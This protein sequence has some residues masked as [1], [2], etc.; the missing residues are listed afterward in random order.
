[1]A[2]TA[3]TGNPVL[4]FI[5]DTAKTDKV[6]AGEMMVQ[7]L[8]AGNPDTLTLG[9]SFGSALIATA[10]HLDLT[11]RETALVAASIHDELVAKAGA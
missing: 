4:D 6:A 10:Q 11:P 1:M 8:M 2:L 5:L 3:P 9:Y 7:S